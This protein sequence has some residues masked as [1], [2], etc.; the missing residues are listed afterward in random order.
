M[1]GLK[2]VNINLLLPFSILSVTA[3]TLPLHL[4]RLFIKPH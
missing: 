2:A 3:D 1:N 4:H